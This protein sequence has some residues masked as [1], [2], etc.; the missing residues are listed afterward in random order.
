MTVREEDLREPGFEG[1]G[2]GA[3]AGPFTA[4]DYLLAVDL[5]GLVGVEAYRM[6]PLL[7]HHACELAAAAEVEPGIAPGIDRALALG[8]VVV[9]TTSPTL[10]MR[11]VPF[12]DYDA[13]CR[14]LDGILVH[15]W[16]FVLKLDGHD[17]VLALGHRSGDQG[18]GIRFFT[19]FAEVWTLQLSRHLRSPVVEHVAFGSLY[20]EARLW[21]R[22]VG[23][24]ATTSFTEHEI[25]VQQEREQ[26]RR[27]AAVRR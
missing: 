21:E 22:T 15:R 10:L 4:D 17:D 2:S 14:G 23:R 27:R 18:W 26:A 1:E 5:P 6:Y 16:G 8:L 13:V 11:K 7:W 25:R 9:P 24:T 12:L 20:E 3:P 19:E